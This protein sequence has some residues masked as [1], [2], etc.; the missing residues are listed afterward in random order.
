MPNTQNTDTK[1]VSEKTLL[2][3]PFND[4]FLE[5]NQ[6]IQEDYFNCQEES[7]TLTEEY[8]LST[9][10]KSII[11][12]LPLTIYTQQTPDHTKTISPPHL[13]IDSGASLNVLKN[14]TWN[15]IK[16]YHKSQLKASPF[17]LSAANNSRLQS[18]C[19]IKLTL[20]PDNSQVELDLYSLYMYQTQNSISQAHFS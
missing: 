4:L 15:K 11:W 6:D 13:E 14:D 7:I 12:V 16:E 18:N 9:S 8:I 2:E 17:V 1:N 3:Q 10:C 19:T 5:L 20:Y